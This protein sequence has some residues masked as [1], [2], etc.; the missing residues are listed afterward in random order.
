MIDAT[1]ANATSSGVCQPPAPARK[2]NAAPLLNA[3][4]RLK[5]G[6]TS[7]RSPGAKRKLGIEG[8]EKSEAAKAEI[9]DRGLS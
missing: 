2:L 7:S 3:S 1:T 9:R 5:N 8:L 4:T 6:A